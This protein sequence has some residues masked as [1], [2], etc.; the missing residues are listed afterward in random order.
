M[1]RL[2]DSYCPLAPQDFWIWEHQE[3]SRGLSSRAPPLWGF[4]G[5]NLKA[6]RRENYGELVVGKSEK[7]NTPEMTETVWK[8]ML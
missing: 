7:A 4:W 6:S 2:E 5:T 8:G 1:V 3:R